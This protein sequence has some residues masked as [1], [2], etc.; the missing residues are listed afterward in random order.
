MKEGV[1]EESEARRKVVGEVGEAM[2]EG[3]GGGG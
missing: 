1:G 3:V 2:K